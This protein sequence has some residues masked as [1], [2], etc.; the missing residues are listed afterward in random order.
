MSVRSRGRR[1][2]SRDRRSARRT[3]GSLGQPRRRRAAT[4]LGSASPGWRP[5]P[6]GVRHRLG[7]QAMDRK[8]RAGLIHA[9]SMLLALILRPVHSRL[10]P[11]PI[12]DALAH[13]AADKFPETDTGIDALIAT[14]APTTPAILDALTNGHLFFDPG[15][16]KSLLPRRVRHARRRRDRRQ[17]GRRDG[18]RPQEGSAQQRHSLEDRGCGRRA[19]SPVARPHETPRR[20]RDGVPCARRQGARPRRHALAKENDP[21]IKSALLQAHAAILA[22]SGDG[23]EP[24]RLAAIST[25]KARGDADAMGLSTRWPRPRTPRRP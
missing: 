25:L 16:H 14:G 19:R 21:A 10:G 3:A 9:A 17:G 6:V 2:C 22:V 23:T 12:D 7:S 18:W 15:S 24:D 5:S 1:S 4:W 8:L 11:R 20:G 13:F